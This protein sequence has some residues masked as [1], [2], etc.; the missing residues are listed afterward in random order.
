MGD[1]WVADYGVEPTEAS[2]GED[3]DFWWKINTYPESG[4]SDY[5]Y[6]YVDG[7]QVDD[8]P[9]YFDQDAGTQEKYT[10]TWSTSFGDEGTYD[11]SEGGDIEAYTRDG[12]YME[13]IT[14]TIFE[15]NWSKVSTLGSVWSNVLD[16]GDAPEGNAG[17]AVRSSVNLSQDPSFSTEYQNDTDHDKFIS[18]D[19]YLTIYC[20]DTSIVR[21]GIIVDLYDPNTGEW[22][23]HARAE[24]AHSPWDDQDTPGMIDNNQQMAFVVPKGYSWRYRKDNEGPS[25]EDYETYLQKEHEYELNSAKL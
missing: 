25:S 20:D 1:Y 6:V 5:L 2:E 13:D 4:A 8:S 22:V 14:I 19:V 3:I 21:A 16:D 18:T 24:I 11:V 17:N 23:E 10:I 12:D 7:T 9:L 15:G